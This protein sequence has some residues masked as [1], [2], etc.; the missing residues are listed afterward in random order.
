MNAIHYLTTYG[1]CF[2]II[3]TSTCVSI[4]LMSDEKV[5]NQLAN[6]KYLTQSNYSSI[7][8]IIALCRFQNQYGGCS[9][10]NARPTVHPTEIRSVK[11]VL[12]VW[13]HGRLK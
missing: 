3:M 1:P 11:A 6:K 7:T 4:L 10:A 5:L 13:Q 9:E 12:G 8:E 2:F